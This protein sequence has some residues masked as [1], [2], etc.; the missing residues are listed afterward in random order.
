MS[1]AIDQ[2]IRERIDANI[3][4]KP[5]AWW[6]TDQPEAHALG[7]GERLLARGPIAIPAGPTVELQLRLPEK[8]LAAGGTSNERR[9]K[10]HVL[11]LGLDAALAGEFE[12][13][14]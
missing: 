5:L 10:G 14:L 6:R 11:L 2:V 8:L 1:G 9:T 7:G 4:S 3:R 13:T 12:A